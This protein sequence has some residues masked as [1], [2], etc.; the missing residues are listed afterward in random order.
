MSFIF[1]TWFYMNLT[2]VLF[3]LSI[4][5]VMCHSVSSNAISPLP[6]VFN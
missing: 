2:Y 6:Y 1:L 4:F 3:L 5:R